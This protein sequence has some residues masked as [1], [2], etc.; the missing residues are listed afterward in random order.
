MLL[1]HEIAKLHDKV[2]KHRRQQDQAASLQIS[3]NDDAKDN[4]SSLHQSL[5]TG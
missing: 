2:G 4:N 5:R 3:C 1:K